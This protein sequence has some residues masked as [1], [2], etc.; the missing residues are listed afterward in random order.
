MLN[1]FDCPANLLKSFKHVGYNAVQKQ[2]PK[3]YGGFILALEKYIMTIASA[4]QYECCY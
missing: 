3:P 1:F 2:L 4:L